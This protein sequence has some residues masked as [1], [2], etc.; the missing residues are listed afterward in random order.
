MSAPAITV[1][2]EATV[3]MAARLLARRGIK[4]A[5]VVDERGRLVG[6]VSRAD[7]LRLFLRDDPAI[8]RELVDDVLLRALWIEPSMVLVTVE[9]GVVT[10]TGHLEC[11]SLAEMA[12]RLTRA[13][14]GVV[15]V[16]S[17][18]TFEEADDRLRMP[19]APFLP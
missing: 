18:L 16:V 6:I 9:D 14:P 3:P 12:V 13:V 8:Y 17:R 15:D 10:L 19:A 4:H 2:P 7:L 5:P 1:N 11:R